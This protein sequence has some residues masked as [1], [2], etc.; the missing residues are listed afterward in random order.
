[1]LPVT[2]TC[3]THLLLFFLN[4]IYWMHSDKGST[5][6]Y[7]IHAIPPVF[8]NV[9]KWDFQK[10]SI[11]PLLL[12]SPN[13]FSRTFAADFQLTIINTSFNGSLYH[14][15]SVFILKMFYKS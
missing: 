11:V 1:M 12:P 13:D 2:G 7:A 5:P 14:I 8:K 15:L 9:H 10:R 3:S 4:N 6:R